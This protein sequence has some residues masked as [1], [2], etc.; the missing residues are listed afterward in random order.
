WLE[1]IVC[2]IYWWYPLLGWFRRRLR[3]SEEECCDMWVVAATDGR[4]SYATALV[5]ATAFLGGPDRS[6]A[7]VLASG[8]GPVQN[9]ERRVTMIMRASGPARLTRF[10]L[11]TVLVIGGLGL[12]FGPAMAQQERRD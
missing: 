12:A 5:E 10:G 11:A 8:A 4:K 1:L 3:E 6:R 2:G 9:L 7:P